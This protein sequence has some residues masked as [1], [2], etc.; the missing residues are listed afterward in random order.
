M[1][2]KNMLRCVFLSLVIQ[3]SEQSPVIPR[4]S[5]RRISAIEAAMIVRRSIQIPSCSWTICARSFVEYEI[6]TFSEMETFSEMDTTVVLPHRS[7]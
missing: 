6:Q 4:Q 2:T 7:V 1:I 5:V 3:L